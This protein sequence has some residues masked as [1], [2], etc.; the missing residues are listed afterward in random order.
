[1]CP[2][3]DDSGVF[4]MITHKFKARVNK[5]AEQLLKIPKDL[6]KNV[7]FYLA[8]EGNEKVCERRPM[9]AKLSLCI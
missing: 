6:F 4:H 9:L 2:T 3:R 8:E 5:M 7:K 1:M